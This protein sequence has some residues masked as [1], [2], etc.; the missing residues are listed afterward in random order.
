MSANATLPKITVAFRML[1]S[2]FLE[3]SERGIAILI[4]REEGTTENDEYTPVT[5]SIQEVTLATDL[6]AWS[7]ANAA[8]IA[9]ML[10][11]GP[12]K[13]VVVTIDATS[14]TLAEAEAL[15][16]HNYQNGRVTLVSSTASDYTSLATWAKTKKSYHALVFNTSSQNSRYVENIYNQNIV[17]SSSWDVGRD[18]QGTLVRSTST[19]LELLPMIAAILSKA[20]VNGASS[21]VL[22][23]LESVTDVAS[24]DTVVNNGNIIVY[25][26]WSDGERVVRLGTAV[27]T[28]TSFDNTEDNG[29]KIEDMRYI[30]ISETADMIRQDITSVFR[31]TYSGQKKN[32]VD[33]QMQLLGAINDYFDRLAADDILNS[34]MENNADIDIDAQRAAWVTVNPEAAG[35]DDNAVKAKPF[36]RNV[37]L[38]ANI[39]I[40]HSMQNMTLNI[41]LD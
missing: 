40:L 33:N 3:R 8:R 2:T 4:V 23:A 41:T 18:G 27:N 22:E 29:D 7:N 32:S 39:Q 1:A 35:W 37:Y 31:D 34:E 13:V 17:F 5:A 26:D 15:I 16:E 38:A 28:L 9:D 36:Q 6:T 20:N 12:S 24:P 19:T 14:G 10:E 11:I 25:N 30:E 21:K